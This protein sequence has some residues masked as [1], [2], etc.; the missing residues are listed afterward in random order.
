LEK[1]ATFAHLL[2]GNEKAQAPANIGFL[3]L[4]I[5]SQGS[6]LRAWGK[7]KKIQCSIH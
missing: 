2:G 4:P 6:A 7:D 1:N 3:R 5:S